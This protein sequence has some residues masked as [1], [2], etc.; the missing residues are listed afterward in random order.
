MAYLKVISPPG[1]LS[2]ISAIHHKVH[3]ANL[4]LWGWRVRCLCSLYVTNNVHMPRGPISNGLFV[5]TS[6]P[7]AVQLRL[8]VLSANCCDVRSILHRFPRRSLR[9]SLLSKC[10]KSYAKNKICWTWIRIVCRSIRLTLHMKSASCG[11]LTSVLGLTNCNY[12]KTSNRSPRLVCG[13]RRLSGARLLSEV[14][15][16]SYV[17]LILLIFLYFCY[18]ALK[19]SCSCFIFHPTVHEVCITTHFGLNGQ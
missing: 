7:H 5:E 15:R 17:V 13:A 18:N 10:V 16:Y 1:C 4:L 14:L 6:T 11:V 9:R 2:P 19:C 3:V 12:R 8:H